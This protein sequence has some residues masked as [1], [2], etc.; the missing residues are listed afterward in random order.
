MNHANAALAADRRTGCDLKER[1]RGGRARGPIS[2]EAYE[3]AL[4]AYRERAAAHLGET[5]FPQAPEGSHDVDL[6]ETDGVSQM[7]AAQGKEA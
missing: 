6:R 3:P 2:A 7:H 4:I 1:M 5:L